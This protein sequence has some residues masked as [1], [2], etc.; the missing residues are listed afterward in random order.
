MTY[1]PDNLV[2]F[3]LTLAILALAVSIALYASRPR[4]RKPKKRLH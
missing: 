2:F 1:N 4:D 3:Y